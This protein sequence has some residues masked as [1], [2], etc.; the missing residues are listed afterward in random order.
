MNAID[1]IDK[2]LATIDTMPGTWGSSESL[3]LQTLLLLEIRAVVLRQNDEN[4]AD[5][6]LSYIR[7][8]R[9]HVKSA[10]S[11]NLSIQ[12]LRAGR[13]DELP[14]LLAKFRDQIIAGE[15]GSEV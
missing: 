3:E 10:T 6:R 1:Y 4:S 5:V 12:L 7:F 11:E 15:S 13:I 2:R 8:I 14:E 9:T